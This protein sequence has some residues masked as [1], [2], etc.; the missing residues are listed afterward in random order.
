MLIRWP[1]CR[2]RYRTAWLF[3]QSHNCS[4]IFALTAILLAFAIRILPLLNGKCIFARLSAD[5]PRS[6]FRR[7][8]LHRRF[9]PPLLRCRQ[10]I[11]FCPPL[12][13]GPIPIIGFPFA[14]SHKCAAASA[15]G[16]HFAFHRHHRAPFRH[17]RRT[18]HRDH[19][20]CRAFVRPPAARPGRSRWH[21][22]PI[23]FRL[24]SIQACLNNNNY[25]YR[26]FRRYFRYYYSSIRPRFI[27]R[28]FRRHSA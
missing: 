4:H 1:I 20:A 18:G 7:Y 15:F 11:S 27:L 16:H 3:G 19:P 14:H 8:S 28:R 25:R 6:A 17:R 26:Q 24:R 21:C 2:F 9:P 5:S 22:Q 13:P 10:C 12:L 23:A